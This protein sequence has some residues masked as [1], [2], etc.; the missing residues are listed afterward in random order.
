MKKTNKNWIIK[1]ALLEIADEMEKTENGEN[2]E[3]IITQVEAI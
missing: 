1:E 2:A 3:E